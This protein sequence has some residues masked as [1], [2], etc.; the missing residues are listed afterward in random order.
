MKL[1]NHGSR[2]H[3]CLSLC[4]GLHLRSDLVDAATLVDVSCIRHVC[5]QPVLQPTTRNHH[6]QGT[7]LSMNVRG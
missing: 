7:D 5:L 1:D 2:L 3:V 6:Q 4:P